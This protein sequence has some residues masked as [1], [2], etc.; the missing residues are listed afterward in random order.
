MKKKCQLGVVL[1]V[2]RFTPRFFQRASSIAE[3]AKGAR[4]LPLVTRPAR[5]K[6][7]PCMG[8]M[9]SAMD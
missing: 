8:G 2:V 5:E 6:S 9:R 3:Q 4:G 7:T 1:G